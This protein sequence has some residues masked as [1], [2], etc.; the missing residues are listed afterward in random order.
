MTQATEETGGKVEGAGGNGGGEKVEGGKDVKGAEV[1]V[2]GEG[3][4]GLRVNGKAEKA[5]ESMVADMESE[6][7]PEKTD[8]KKNADGSICEDCQ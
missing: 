5:A 3:F 7:V 1:K 4:E 8:V 2:E 6:G